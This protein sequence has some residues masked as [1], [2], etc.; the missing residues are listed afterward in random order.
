M[1]V[2]RHPGPASTN[3]VA[4][5]IARLGGMTPA[6]VATGYSTASLRRWQRAGRVPQAVRAVR[7]AE[8]AG[9]PVRELV[10]GAD[11]DVAA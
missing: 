6:T 8:L 1:A 3:P 11:A 2:R 10:L 4:Q 9:M 5:A 7:L